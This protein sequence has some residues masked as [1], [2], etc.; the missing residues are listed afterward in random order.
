[1]RHGK[2]GE[3]IQSCIEFYSPALDDLNRN[4]Q[5][6]VVP[7]EYEQMEAKVLELSNKNV[8]Q[9][10]AYQVSSLS[11]LFPCLDLAQV[12]ATEERDIALISRLYFLL[13]SKLELHW[14]LDQINNQSVANHWQ[15]M[16]RAAYREELDWQQRSLTTV[17]LSWDKNGK[18]ADKI[19]D[20]WIDEQQHLLE[21]WYHMMAEFKTSKT[22][23]FAK[24]SVALRELMLLSL[25]CG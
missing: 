12:A 22:H 16:A 5:R 14:F 3:N 11:N 7:E 18:N 19:L 17:L 4:L 1:M 8:P 25:N 2:K 21:R 13:G 15:A 23:E 9:G 6:Y 24:F 10:I 20:K